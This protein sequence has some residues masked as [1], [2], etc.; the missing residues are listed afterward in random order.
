VDATA[1]DLAKR[2]QI[3][4]MTSKTGISVP[5]GPGRALPLEDSADSSAVREAMQR[6][7]D[8]ERR[9]VEE[10]FW[11]WPHQLGQSQN[12]EALAAL[13]Q[14][15]VVAAS[16]IWLRY[17]QYHSEANVSMHNLAVL[18]HTAALDFEHVAL[19]ELLSDRQKKQRDLYWQQ[20]F[21]RW[22]VL[23]E[24]EGFWSRL[25]ARIR[26]LDDPR[27]TTG[28]ARRI[29]AS[30]PLTLLLINARLAVHAAEQGGTAEVKRH[31]AIM[32]VVSGFEQRV[33]DEALRRAVAP[34]RER[35]K[36][37]CK[38]TET[39]ANADPAHADEV[40]RRLV[41]QTKPLLDVL[42]YLLPSGNPTRDSMHDEVAIRALQCQIAFGNKTNNWK[43]SLELLELALRITVTE[44]VR[45]R[46]KENRD[47]VKN[48]LEYGMCFFCK[49][50]P[51]D[52]DAAVEVKMYGDV[53]RQPTFTGT[54]IQWR[55][56]TLKVPRCARC[57]SAH[58]R[59]DSFS[60]TGAAIGFLV[61]LA[62]CA[63]VSLSADD[64]ICGG[65]IVLA[66]VSAIGYGIGYLIG[67]RTLP[68]GVKPESAKNEFS[69][70]RDLIRQG[71]EFGEKPSTN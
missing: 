20:A 46:I 2:Q 25:T 55:T 7:R 29:R 23:L 69:S 66:V 50:F 41:A 53:T 5:P 59:V 26:D 36:T 42:D 21:N 4:E 67:Q 48:N 34:I 40:T 14:G 27:L 16:E 33:I 44:S 24:Y 63:G 37:L 57:K 35:I 52:D 13:A 58:G 60:G 61:G 31:L 9:L 28:T 10:F 62:G 19:S 6:L 49:E 32:Q 45:S 70:V 1:R 3:V 54:R 12:D 71:W 30:L 17:E 22:K 65:L 51:G 39:E 56:A 64:A 11:F 38:T 8:P 68:S 15:D 18:S 43:I 47:I